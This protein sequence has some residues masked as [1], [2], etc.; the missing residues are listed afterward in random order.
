MRRSE[1]EALMRKFDALQKRLERMEKRQIQMD[2]AV[3]EKAPGREKGD[4]EK[5]QAETEPPASKPENE[6]AKPPEKRAS[7]HLP[8]PDEIT[9]GWIRAE[10]WRQA[11]PNQV[12]EMQKRGQ[13]PMRK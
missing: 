12:P 2:Q 4:E 8:T 5:I 3:K 10:E 13:A 9:P 7:L 6:T 1:Y 11:E